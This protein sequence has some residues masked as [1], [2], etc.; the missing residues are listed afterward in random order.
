MRVFEIPNQPHEYGKYYTP[1]HLANLFDVSLDDVGFFIRLAKVKPEIML[2]GTG[3]YSREAVFKM[4][5]AG[6]GTETSDETP[7]K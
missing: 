2:D 5:D 7:A 6:L 3:F 1:V 4:M